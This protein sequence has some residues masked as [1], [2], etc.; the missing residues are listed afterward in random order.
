MTRILSGLV[1]AAVLGGPA[2]AQGFDPAAQRLEMERLRAQTEANALSAS[3]YRAQS[4]VA[5]QQLQAATVNTGGVSAAVSADTA[6]R[7]EARRQEELR[8]QQAQ[9]AA[10]EIERRIR[11]AG[12]IPR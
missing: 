7:A 6:A 10:L 12:A 11:A 4:A 5:V 3:A 1:A 9:D 2:L 8:R